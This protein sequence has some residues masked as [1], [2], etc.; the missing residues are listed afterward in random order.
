MPFEWDQIHRHEEDLERDAQERAIE[1]VTE[2]YSISE[3]SELTAEQV[4]EIEN[5]QSSF[6]EYSVMQHGL[7]HVVH[8]WHSANS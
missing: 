6:N 2:F 1:Y 5:F 4:A 3:V 7:N 8:E